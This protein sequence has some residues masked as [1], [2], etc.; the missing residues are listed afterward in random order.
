[1]ARHQSAHGYLSL[2][3]PTIGNLKLARPASPGRPTW[4]GVG[5]EGVDGRV[6]RG[7]LG[8]PGA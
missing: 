5:A 8:R 4:S 6:Q 2:P 3:I 7:L 1:M